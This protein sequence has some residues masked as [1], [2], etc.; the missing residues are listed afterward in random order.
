MEKA[1]AREGKNARDIARFYA[2][3]F[4]DGYKKLNLTEP[5]QFL[6]ATDYIAEQILL[7]QQ[8]EE[9]GLAYK[10]D[11][12]IYF[13]TVAYEALGYTYGELSNLD[14]I[15]A[16]AR[17]EMNTQ[18]KDI[19]DFA[20][21]KF[22]P[23]ENQNAKRDMEWPSPW[24]VGFPGWHIECSAMS[25]KFLGEQFDIH[26]GGEDL[27]S[28]HHPNEI[29]QSQGAT[30]KKPFVKY[31]LHGAFLQVNGGRMGKSLG[32]A[33]TLHDIE[34][35]GIDPLALRYFYFGAH[36]TSPLNFTWEGL[37][38]AAHSLKRLQN[39]YLSLNRTNKESDGNIIT[40]YKDSFINYLNED[41]NMPKALAL[42]WELVQDANITDRDKKATLL[43]FDMVFG[44]NLKD[45]KEEIIPQEI[46]DL[47][48]ERESARA[49][50][51]WAKS[52]ELRDTIKE[53][54]YEV[55]DT[56]TGSTISKI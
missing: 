43:E 29:A 21:W 23:K 19:R 48:I 9:K 52:D 13:N 26:I 22:S 10:I 27:K 14:Q 30:G 4:K 7:V 50:K 40:V 56:D 55:K 24:G 25:M 34:K 45:L 46:K 18:K 17:V 3:D 51:D 6:N 47:V 49:H 37:E 2:E 5:K 39:I 28:T 12:G 15:K 54:G 41:L 1:K 38:S 33:Y 53:L 35:K 8:L 31:W 20:L 16:G 36:Y 42:L 44:F 32:N 11:D